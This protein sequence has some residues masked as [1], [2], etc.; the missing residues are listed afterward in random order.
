[1]SW[2]YLTKRVLAAL[3][4]LAFVMV[5]NFFMFRVLGDPA[6]TMG[7]AQELNPEQ[8][9]ELREAQGIDKPTFP[10]QFVVYLGNTLTGDLGTTFKSS[11]PVTEVLGSRAWPTVLLVG[12]ATI[13]STLIGV[14]LGIKG[15]WKHGSFFDRSS[16]L[17]SMGLYAIPDF[18][19]GMVLLIVFA[20]SLG[21]FPVG[22]YQSP[23]A[24]ASG[25]GHWLD[26]LN[27]LF[28]PC[29]TLTLAYIGEYSLIMRASIIE[30]MGDDYVLTAR[31]KGIREK[32]VLRRHVVPNALLP[33]VT[34]TVLYFGF[35][36][37]GSIGVEYVFSYPGLGLMTAEALDDYDFPVLQGMFLVFSAAVI[38]ANLVADIMYGYLDPRVRINS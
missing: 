2:R 30:V 28:L 24:P 18:F 15:G 32:F 17:G 34:V 10:D 7:R 12:T 6:R 33:I 21:W 8:I 23:G 38:A 3:A 1:M 25:I 26:V 4:T 13:F 29:L 27:H 31:A 14:F 9:Q 19:L 5:I 22:G 20:A 37:A 11:R 16:L 35:L 36:L